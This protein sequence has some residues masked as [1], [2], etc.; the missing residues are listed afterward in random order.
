VKI[1]GDYYSRANLDTAVVD[2]LDAQ[3]R[4]ARKALRKGRPQHKRLGVVR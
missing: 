2:A 3:R 4:Q 1:T